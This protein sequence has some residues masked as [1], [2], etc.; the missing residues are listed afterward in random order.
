MRI[1]MIGPFGMSPKGTMSVRALPLAQS[2][3]RRGHEVS[4][5]IPPWDNP[6]DSGRVYAAGNVVVHNITVPAHLKPLTIATLLYR[7]SMRHSP[8]VIHLFKPKGY[9]GMAAFLFSMA[10]HRFVLDTDDWEGAGGWNDIGGYPAHYRMAFAVQQSAIPKL[11]SGVTVAS[12]ALQAQLGDLGVPESKTFYLPNGAGAARYGG[13]RDERAHRESLRD[14][15]GIAL[16]PVV[17]LYSRFFEFRPE[18]VAEIFAGVVRQVPNARLLVIG[19]GFF[20]EEEKLQ[21]LAESA[22]WLGN[23]LRLGWVPEDKLPSHLSM[24]DVAI[25]PY[26]DNLVNRAKCSVKLIDLM[27]SGLPVVADQVGQNAEYLQDGQ[28]GIL[29]NPG[30]TPA[31]VKGIVELLRDRE[32]RLRMGMAAEERLWQQFNW[33]ELA[34]TAEIAYQAATI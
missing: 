16:D 22:G 3:A 7:E 12:R 4:L 1:A 28:S 31:F 23:L 9:S 8:D 14:S 2:L 30:D 17:L 5:I 33:D 24:A 10:R 6:A 11:A 26:D 13:W 29:V 19:K 18:R 20:H 25:Y 21:A 32:L 15:Y 27:V 34:G